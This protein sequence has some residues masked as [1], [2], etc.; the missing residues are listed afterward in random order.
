MKQGKAANRVAWHERLLGNRWEA[1][2][3]ARSAQYPGGRCE[4]STARRGAWNHDLALTR[5]E[6]RSD[7]ANHTHQ[8]SVTEGLLCYEPMA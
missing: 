5:F 6:R 4:G 7:Q 1:V 3:S 2:R 8:P